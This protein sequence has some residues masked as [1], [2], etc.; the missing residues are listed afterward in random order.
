MLRFSDNTTA[1]M[2]V[3]EVGALKGAG[4]STAAGLDVVRAWIE[5]SGLPA[6]GVTFDDASGLSDADRVTCTFLA[7]LLGNGGPDGVVADGRAVPGQPGT[8]DD[9]FTSG[10]LRDRLR[11]KTGT[12]RQ[13]TGLSG[14]LT[15][16][17]SAPLAF[18]ILT[19][20]SGRQITAADIEVQD[21]L[22]TAMLDYPASP[23]LAALSPAPPSGV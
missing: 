16:R 17:P 7:T 22:L 13:A 11:A 21:R 4:G 5:S 12:L 18:S 9:R 1:E 6:E 14:W 2:L 23:D 20:T 15:T 3:K 10:E 19:N 8:L